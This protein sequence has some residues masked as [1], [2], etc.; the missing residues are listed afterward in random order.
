MRTIE[1]TS[2]RGTIFGEYR[3]THFSPEFTFTDGGVSANLS[4]SI[5]THSL[6]VGVTFRF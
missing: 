3:Y 6:L 4:S 2:L 5:N 1:T